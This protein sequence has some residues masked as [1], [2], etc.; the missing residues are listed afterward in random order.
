MQA[1]DMSQL[2]AVTWCGYGVSTDFEDIKKRTLTAFEDALKAFDWKGVE[3]DAAFVEGMPVDE[4]VS[5]SR[6]ADLVIMGTHGR[7]GLASALLGS[8]AY[9]VLERTTRPVVV[10][11]NPAR[12]LDRPAREEK[13]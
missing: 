12:K 6:N 9:A 2:A 3:H 7:T 10:V 8:V 1:F 4:I 13:S 11:R 5:R